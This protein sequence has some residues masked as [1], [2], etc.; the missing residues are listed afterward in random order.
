MNAAGGSDAACRLVSQQL[1]KRAVLIVNTKSRRGREWFVGAQRKLTELG[2]ELEMAEAFRTLPELLAE[3]EAAVRRNVPMI[4]AG[5]GDGTF[6]ALTPYLVESDTALG[7]LPLG[8]GNAFARDLGIAASLDAACDALVT[9]KLAQVDLG[10]A[11]DHYFLNVATV[12][13]TTLIADELTVKAKRRFGRFV[14]ALA[15]WRALGRVQPFV[16]K[17]R[18]PSGEA[19]FETLQVVVGN[20]RFHAGPFPL[21]PEASITEGRLSLY[22]V[23]TTQRSAFLKLAMYLPSG[24]H[25]G[26]SEVHHE[27]TT[28]GRL[29]TF[30]KLPVTADGEN[31]MSTPFDFGV[32]HCALKV[33]VPQTFAG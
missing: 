24:R 18:T 12:G 10:R 16:A 22:A 6:S 21:S 8:T 9:G 19:E 7:V 4:V 1:P 5:G 15:L 31:C 20:G 33:V 28:E 3:A 13:L 30:P 27:E 25:V 23:K 11:G 2:V 14:Y 29:E 17:L 26:L 32:A